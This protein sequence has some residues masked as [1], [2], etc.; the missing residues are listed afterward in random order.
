MAP[1][2]DA[3]AHVQQRQARKAVTLQLRA[4]FASLTAELHHDADAFFARVMELSEAREAGGP[5][6]DGIEPDDPRRA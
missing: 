5:G 2:L 3:S 6:A 1:A 4:Y